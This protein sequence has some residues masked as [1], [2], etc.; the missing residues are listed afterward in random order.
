VVTANG[1]LL[2]ESANRLG[3]LAVVPDGEAGDRPVLRVR[4][5]RDGYDQD[6]L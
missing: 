2:S 1:Y 6:G 3:R 5:R 4:L